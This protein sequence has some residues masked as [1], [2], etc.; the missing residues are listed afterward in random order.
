MCQINGERGGSR[1]VGERESYNGS[2][3]YGRE[4]E[5]KGKSTKRRIEKA[6]QRGNRISKIGG[7]LSDGIWKKA[8]P[9]KGG[10]G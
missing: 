7:T 9:E 3:R 6:Y 1:G 5:S 8:K 2:R 10:K 4:Q